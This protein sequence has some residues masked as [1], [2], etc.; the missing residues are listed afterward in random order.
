MSGMESA[1]LGVL[2]TAVAWR[3][4]GIPVMLAT[5]VE[6]WGSAPR[7][8]GALLVLS[9]DG[10]LHGSVSGGCIEDDLLDRVRACAAS[11]AGWP[12][13]AETIS[14]GI[15]SE[16][17]MR[18][19]LPCGGTL[20]VVLEPLTDHSQVEA[21]LQAVEARRLVQRTLDLVT[22]VAQIEDC[23]PDTVLN[24]D[25]TTLRSVHGPR[26]RILVIGAGQV[27]AYLDEMASALDFQVL[28]CDPREEYRASWTRPGTPIDERMPDDFVMAL[29][30]DARTAVVALTHDPKQDDLALIEALRSPALYVGAL[31]SRVNQ[32]KRRARLLEF[33][34]TEAQIAR[35]RGPV[36]MPIG[37]RSPPELAIAVLADLIAAR[38]GVR[39]VRA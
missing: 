27:A 13:A 20:R 18:F 38:Q 5:L 6:T 31:G 10:R 39:L 29:A 1:D 7:P 21:L 12:R 9:G 35:L 23:A 36:G 37:S 17:A 3:A 22:G 25:G 16:E 14:Y 33:D 32:E 26:M 15:T 2:R 34:L 30:P 11:S 19:G 28:V 24:F 8:I 4:A